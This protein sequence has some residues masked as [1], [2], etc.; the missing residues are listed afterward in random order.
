MPVAGKMALEG[1]HE[2]LVGEVQQSLDLP[3]PQHGRHGVPPLPRHVVQGR[4]LPLPQ[5]PDGHLPVPVHADH[6]LSHHRHVGDVA[7][8]PLARGRHLAGLHVHQLDEAVLGAADQ[9]V[10][11]HSEAGGGRQG[12]VQGL[13]GDG[14]G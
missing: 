4:L 12:G 9:E 6:R 11:Q 10:G 3:A 8:V 2:E 14:G 1:S 13:G 5:A 7:G